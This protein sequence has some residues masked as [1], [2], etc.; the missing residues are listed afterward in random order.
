MSNV[1]IYFIL[2]IVLL[3][4]MFIVLLERDETIDELKTHVINGIGSDFDLVAPIRQ[5]DMKIFSVTGRVITEESDIIKSVIIGKS[6]LRND[7]I[8]TKLQCSWISSPKRIKPEHISLNVDPEYEDSLKGNYI[9]SISYKGSE[10]WKTDTGIVGISCKILRLNNSSKMHYKVKEDHGEK[11]VELPDSTNTNK[12]EG[13]EEIMK[14]NK[15]YYKRKIIENQM[16]LQF[17]PLLGI[18]EIKIIFTKSYLQ[19]PAID[20][21]NIRTR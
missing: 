2:Y 1:K 3:C 9:F 5:L 19:I 14:G 12:M 11:Y 8:I 17:V 13:D 20:V 16:G 4:E 10:Q 7:S 18:T 15:R 6:F 21:R